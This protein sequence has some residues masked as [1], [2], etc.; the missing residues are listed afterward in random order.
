MNKQNSFISANWDKI[1]STFMQVIYFSNGR[2]LKGYSKKTNHD[3]SPDKIKVLKN[4]ILRMLRDGYLDKRNPSK[5]D[6]DRIEY[7]LNEPQVHV[8]SL[9]YEYFEC[10]N[11]NFFNSSNYRPVSKFLEEFYKLIS[12]G[13]SAEDI[14]SRLYT[15]TKSKSPEPLDFQKKRFLNPDQLIKYAQDLVISKGHSPGEVDH[16]I[17]NYSEKHFGDRIQVNWVHQQ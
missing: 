8:F 10:I 1:G 7:Y 15:R 9:H 2:A 16:F 11:E 6:V 12:Q 5:T 4:M 14:Y 17:T 3:E 13:K